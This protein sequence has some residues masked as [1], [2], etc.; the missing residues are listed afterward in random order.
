MSQSERSQRYAASEKGKAAIARKR[1]REKAKRGAASKGTEAM[2]QENAPAVEYTCNDI[3]S[4]ERAIDEADSRVFHN[5]WVN[6]RRMMAIESL[7][8]ALLARDDR[9]MAYAKPFLHDTRT[10]EEELNLLCDAVKGSADRCRMVARWLSRN[11]TLE[12]RKLRLAHGMFL[13]EGDADFL[14]E[15]LLGKPTSA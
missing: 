11:E 1:E 7:N 14:K 9:F 5:H 4:R 13:D 6:G 12:E 15:L 3:E 2:P 8:R 10:T